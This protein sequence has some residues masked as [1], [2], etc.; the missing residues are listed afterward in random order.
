MWRNVIEDL[1]IRSML[2]TYTYRAMR[3]CCVNNLANNVSIYVQMIYTYINI[4]IRTC[5]NTTGSL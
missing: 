3:A 5:F 1:N 2:Q 4:Y